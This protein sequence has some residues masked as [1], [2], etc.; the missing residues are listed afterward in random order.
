MVVISVIGILASVVL[1]S[2]QNARNKSKDTVIIQELT[3]FRNLYES[4]YTSTNGYSAL[5]PSNPATLTNPCGQFNVSGSN[6]GFFCS[7]LPSGGCGPIFG[8][9]GQIANNTDALNLC[10][11]ILNSAGNFYIGVNDSANLSKEYSIATYLPNQKVYMCMGSSKNNST[12][13]FVHYST[14]P[15]TPDNSPGCSANP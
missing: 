15:T 13:N 5:Q 3:Q 9:S 11:K 2:L 12:T 8:P 14:N 6:Q 4:V 1:A 7:I 10:T